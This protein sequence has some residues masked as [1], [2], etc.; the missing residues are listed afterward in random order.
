MGHNLNQVQI[1]QVD[2]HGNNKGGG[3]LNKVQLKTKDKLQ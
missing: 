3:A 1:L 2:S